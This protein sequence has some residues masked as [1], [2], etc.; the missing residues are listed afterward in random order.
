MVRAIDTA[1]DWK[2]VEGRETVTYFKRIAENRLAA[3]VT[4]PNAKR[5]PV[6]K[7]RLQADSLLA[8]IDVVWRLWKN[9]L[10]A[11]LAG[12][13]PCVGEIIQD[14]AGVRWIVKM[15]EILSLGQSYRLACERSMR[16]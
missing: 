12:H 13:V 9:Q 11:E 8:K 3:G 14:A 6:R 2:L 1:D 7:D 10:P 5:F 4:V 16:T 15:V